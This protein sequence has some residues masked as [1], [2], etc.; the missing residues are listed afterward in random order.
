MHSFM[1][2]YVC[3]ILIV[4]SFCLNKRIEDKIG[5]KVKASASVLNPGWINILLVC[6]VVAS[7]EACGT[8][9][10][11]FNALLETVVGNSMARGGGN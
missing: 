9:D 7:V 2:C 6:A 10:Q 11:A 1:T 3:L 5:S 8:K 4:C